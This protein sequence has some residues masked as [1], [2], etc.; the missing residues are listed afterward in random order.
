MLKTFF[1]T[2]KLYI[3]ALAF[4]AY[5]AGLW[6]VASTYTEAKYLGKQL[7]VAEAVIKTTEQNDAI[8]K[9]I[10]KAVAQEL[11]KWRAEANKSN[12]KLQDA[13]KKDPVYT[14]CKSNPDVMREYQ[15][16]LD[17]QPK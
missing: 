4:V 1:N 2:Y 3:Y 11:A 16:K 12:R 6:H 8:K 14:D 5:S 17:S 9:E 13:I 15:N 7:D 10:S